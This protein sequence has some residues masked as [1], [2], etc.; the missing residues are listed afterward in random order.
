MSLP[1]NIPT[2]ML[3]AGFLFGTSVGFVSQVK[4]MRDSEIRQKE[5]WAKIR[6]A[7]PQTPPPLSQD[8]IDLALRLFHIKV[9]KDAV[10]PRYNP[11]LS[12][13]GSAS[14]KFASQKI[15][16]EIGPSAFNSWS[17]LGSTLAHELEVHCL[18][19]WTVINLM[20]MLGLN[21]S[22]WAERQAYLFEIHNA[23][24]FGLNTKQIE[25]IEATMAYFYDVDR[26]DETS[27]RRAFS[28]KVGRW[29]ARSVYVP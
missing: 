24:R 6:V 13:R 21:G 23:K 4:I 8:S 7:F 20:D 2:Q 16:V 1:W 29:M 9:P 17:L 3:I 28:A 10:Y 11:R 22:M 27:L 18:Q 5:E 25:L 26:H 19:N 14:R 15:V 12:D